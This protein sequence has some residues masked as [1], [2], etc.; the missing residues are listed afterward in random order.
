MVAESQSAEVIVQGCDDPDSLCVI[1]QGSPS[2]PMI[3][4]RCRSAYLK[5]FFIT[6]V[7]IVSEAFKPWVRFSKAIYIITKYCIDIMIDL[8]SRVKHLLAFPSFK[9][10]LWCFLKIILALFDPKVG[11][12]LSKIYWLSTVYKSIAQNTA[13]N[14]VTPNCRKI[15]DGIPNNSVGY[16]RKLNLCGLPYLRRCE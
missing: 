14:C 3:C 1:G 12:V 15:D 4:L 16:D 11:I 10:S 5:M 7:A 2:R 6:I 13:Q 9:L 8:I